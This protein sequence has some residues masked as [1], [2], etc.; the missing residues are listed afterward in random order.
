MG[1]R[2]VRGVGAGDEPLRTSAWEARG[3]CESRSSGSAVSPG[4]AK[5]PPPC[6]TLHVGVITLLKGTT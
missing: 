1:G 4:E 5:G 2:N 6:N 3:P